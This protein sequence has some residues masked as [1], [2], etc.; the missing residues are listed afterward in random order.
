MK[1]IEYMIAPNN[2]NFPKATEDETHEN[3]AKYNN[4]QRKKNAIKTSVSSLILAANVLVV[5][6]A[7]NTV[8]T[9][10]IPQRLS[11]E[12]EAAENG[13]FNIE[14]G[15]Y[16]G[17][18]FFGTMMG[19]GTLTLDS[20]ELMSG[21]W[22]NNVFSGQG[23]TLYPNGDSYVGDYRNSVREG[24]GIF[25]WPDG[26]QYEG[27]WCSDKIC[28]NGTY[29]SKEGI[30]FKGEFEDNSFK[31]GVCTF[32]FDESNGTLVYSQGEL[33]KVDILC[34]DGTAFTLDLKTGI[35]ETY[36]SEGDYFNGHYLAGK[37]N[38]TGEY[39]WT[40]GDVYS[41]NWENDKMNG[42]GIYTFADGSYAE[43]SFKDNLLVNG[44]IIFTDTYGE[45]IYTVSNGIETQVIFTASDG[46]TYNGDITGG[47]LTGNA[48]I[49][50]S[51]G[52]VYNGSVVNGMKSGIGDYKWND[53]ASY[54]GSW[55][56]D[57]MDGE[58]TY[59]YR[60]SDKGYALKGTFKNGKPNGSCYYYTSASKSYKTD[61]DNGRCIKIYE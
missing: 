33:E 52:D 58:G 1:R 53:G 36:Y 30:I 28:G 7:G 59:Y 56:N 10:E 17:E 48:E 22:E 43:G 47:Q 12:I 42:K 24:Q 60:S 11:N 37:R 51:N 23:E 6:V 45:C 25:T 50:Y 35:G 14:K 21:D 29:T 61:W 39:V 13:A 32:A 27:E 19:S 34:E 55:S 4:V 26:S 54:S 18:S 57:L 40:T 5:M 31:T 8:L 15:I 3:F 49:K 44:K 9:N 2:L 38:G 20:G 46:T 16:R 41:G